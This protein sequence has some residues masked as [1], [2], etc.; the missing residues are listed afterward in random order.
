MG[1]IAPPSLWSVSAS[2]GMTHYQN[3][4]SSDGET[5]I[6]RLALGRELITRSWGTLGLELGVQNGNTMRYVPSQSA[7]DALGGLPI[8]TTVKP[9]LDLLATVKTM[10]LG[11]TAMVGLVKGGVAYRHWQFNDRD[12]INDCSQLAGEFQVGVGYALNER[13]SLSL[14]YQGIYGA[15]PHFTLNSAAMTGHVSNIPIQNGVLL[16]LTWQV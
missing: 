11:N 3:M 16:G 9:M 15:N 14:V 12:S 4:F 13:A 2:L 8:Q 7:I 1:A 10:P 6:G 5:A